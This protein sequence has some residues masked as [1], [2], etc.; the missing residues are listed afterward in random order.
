MIRAK[1]F[2]IDILELQE[3]KLDKVAKDFTNIRIMKEFHDLQKTLFN[4]TASDKIHF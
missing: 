4:L 2:Y 3:L 1:S